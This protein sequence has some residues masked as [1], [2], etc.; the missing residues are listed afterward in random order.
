M[1]TVLSGLIGIKRLIF[2]N[3]AIVNGNILIGHNHK[4]FEVFNSLGN[5]NLKTQPNMC[6]LLKRECFYFGYIIT[7]RTKEFP[8]TTDVKIYQID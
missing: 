8:L 4:L 2:L 5:H 7:K 3:D 6:E 1:N